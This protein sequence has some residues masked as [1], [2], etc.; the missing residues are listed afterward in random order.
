VLA[1]SRTAFEAARWLQAHS[2]DSAPMIDRMAALYIEL[3]RIDDARTFTA[4]YAPPTTPDET[5]GRA[6]NRVVVGFGAADVDELIAVSDTCGKPARELACLAVDGFET[7][8]VHTSIAC[9]HG[10]SDDQRAAVRAMRAYV[11]WPVNAVP[12]QTWLAIGT[13]AVSALQIPG[14]PDMAIAALTN[15]AVTSCHGSALARVAALAGQVLA[16]HGHDASDDARW[17]ALAG[18][19]PVACEGLRVEVVAARGPR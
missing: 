4:R 14:A 1:D 6:I 5:C 10:G 12:D 13:L 2:L 19:T 7:G 8:V 11:A 17:K 18:L 9:G 3:A 15:A 16:T